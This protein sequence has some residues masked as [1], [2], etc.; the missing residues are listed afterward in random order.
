MIELGR[1]SEGRGDDAI[2]LDHALDWASFCDFF[3]SCSLL[4]VN[5]S[6]DRKSDIEMG[7]LCGLWAIGLDSEIM[8]DGA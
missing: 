5:V 1:V 6:S 7:D 3:E 8:G 2:G 4:V